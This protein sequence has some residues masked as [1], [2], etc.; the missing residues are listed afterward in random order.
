MLRKEFL[1]FPMPGHRLRNACPRIAIPIV[2]SAITDENASRFFELADQGRS[3]SSN[4]KLGDFA[5]TRNFAARQVL[6]KITKVPFKFLNRFSLSQV[7]REIF[8]V[9]KPHLT[10]LP[11][12]VPRGA[13]G[14]ILPFV[15][16]N[17]WSA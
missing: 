6:V 7:I 2:L 8:E 15:T 4:R 12:Y 5:D 9:A 1:D 13:H 17:G 14:T 3:A 16:L 10:V 11:M